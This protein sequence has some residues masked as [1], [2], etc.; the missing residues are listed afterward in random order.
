TFFQTVCG[1][2]VNISQPTVSRIVQ[3]VSELLA[4]NIPR[5]VHF[6]R[7]E[8]QKN[9]VKADFLGIAGFP[10]VLGCV[11]GTQIPIISPGGQNAEVYRNRKGFMS[12]N[13]QL[14][15]GPQLQ[16]FD[17]VIRWPGST[18]DSRIFSNSSLRWRFEN[19]RGDLKNSFLLGDS[20]YA[21]T[22]YMYT[23]VLDPQTA[24]E[25]R[26]NRA[27]IST[28]NT[29]ERTIGVLKRRFPCMLYELRNKLETTTRII[30]ACIVL[31]NIGRQWDP[32]D[33][34]NEDVQLIPNN[35]Q[36]FVVDVEERVRDNERGRLIKELFI[37]RHFS[38]RRNEE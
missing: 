12:I 20:G 27:Q 18:H 35:W 15:A 13:V 19:P 21:Q 26:Y 16:I 1:D 7:N 36:N 32:R 4:R 22:K 17:A 30:A 3:E 6:P 10:N 31:H 11:D 24:A 34:G 33:F 8:A 29:V 2:L 28:R 37:H 23:P 14:V 5:L 9:L 38:N 25:Q